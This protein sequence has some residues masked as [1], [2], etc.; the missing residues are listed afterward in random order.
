MKVKFIKLKLVKFTAVLLLTVSTVISFSSFVSDDED[1]E[2]KRR[3]AVAVA[4]NYQCWYQDGGG[5]WYFI[6]HAGLATDCP[7]VDYISSCTVE[8]CAPVVPC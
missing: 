1:E 4:C 3:K 8:A 5:N 7:R 6:I 2:A